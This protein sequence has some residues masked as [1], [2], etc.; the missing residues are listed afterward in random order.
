MNVAAKAM[1][2]LPAPSPAANDQIMDGRIM[3]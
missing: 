2:T 1:K 3:R